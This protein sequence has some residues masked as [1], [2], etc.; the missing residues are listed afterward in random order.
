MMRSCCSSTDGPSGKHG[1]ETRLYF[2]VQTEKKNCQHQ[3]HLMLW[4]IN[5]EEDQRYDRSFT[6]HFLAF[7]VQDE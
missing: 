6:D 3:H 1:C 7:D 4:L 2:Q 5:M